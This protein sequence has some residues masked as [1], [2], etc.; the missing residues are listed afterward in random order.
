MTWF[1]RAHEAAP[2][3]EPPTPDEDSPAAL[4]GSLFGLV[5]FINAN[6]GRLPVEAVVV[7]RRIADTVREVIDTSDGRELDIYAVVAV[8][9]IIADYLPTTLRSYLALD[10]AQVEVARP[11]GRTPNESLIEQLDSLW[12][13]AT[14]LLAAAQSRDADA[15]LTQ[16]N[17]LKTKFTRSDLDL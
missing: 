11:S 6:S 16:G 13:S 15:L 9:G 2:P 14:D 17:F 12:E 10:P 3:G 1:R 8:K 5:V 4:L 7:A